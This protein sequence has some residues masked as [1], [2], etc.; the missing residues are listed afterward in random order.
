MANSATPATART[1]KQGL[2]LAAAAALALPIAVVAPAQQA[3]AAGLGRTGVATAVSQV[4]MRSGASTRYRVVRVLHKGNNVTLN[5]AAHGNWQ[6]VRIGTLR[7]WVS[8]KYLRKVTAKKTTRRVT[9]SVGGSSVLAPA[10]SWSGPSGVTTRGRTIA[11]TV[12]QNFPAIS[13]VY[14]ARAERGSD[15]S[16]GHAI[17]VML[18]GNYRGAAQQRLGAQIAAYVRANAS[19]LGI[20]Y[21]IWHQHIWNVRRDAEGWR[22]MANRGSDN[23]NH[24][25]HVHISYR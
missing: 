5:G 23:A 6:P 8:V 12:H 13:T 24:V 18:P 16:T 25:N 11:A 2:G 21:V 7:G 17:D 14:G 22:L 20:T 19:R 3:Q 4:N 10:S 15:H 9:S 1:A